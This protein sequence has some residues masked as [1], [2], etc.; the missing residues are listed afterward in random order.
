MV[1]D[2]TLDEK[3]LSMPSTETLR[4]TPKRKRVHVCR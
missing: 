3:M 2:Q 1:V 4:P